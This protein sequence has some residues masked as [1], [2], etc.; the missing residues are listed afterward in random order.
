MD[1]EFNIELSDLNQGI[2]C[3]ILNEKY[4]FGNKKIKPHPLSRTIHR[5]DPKLGYIKGNVIVIS[6]LANVVKNNGTLDELGLIVKKLSY[7]ETQKQKNNPWQKKFIENN[8]KEHPLSHSIKIKLLES[9]R[10]RAKQ[11]K[12]KY[13]LSCDV[14]PIPTKCFYLK[15][16]ID[17]N[18]GKV[19]FNSPTIDRINNLKGYTVNN[20]VI[21]SHK[22][23]LMKNSCSLE[24]LK[25]IY[26][27]FKKI[28]IL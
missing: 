22:A 2:W 13:S 3:P 18:I 28:D 26:N 9:A 14:L 19:D 6:S 1:I 15:I 24:Y 20:I 27:G 10:R 4:C 11:H 8:F 12:R 17:K 7:L 23:N 21:C 5:I 25:K 16:P